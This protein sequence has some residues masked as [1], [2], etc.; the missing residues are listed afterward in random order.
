MK[1]DSGGGGGGVINE[2]S[3][4]YIEKLRTLEKYIEP[5]SKEIVDFFKF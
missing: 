5:L 2:L 1:M 3:P 4:E